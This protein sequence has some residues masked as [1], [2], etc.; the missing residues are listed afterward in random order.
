MI[1][2]ARLE[3]VAQL[4]R[5]EIADILRRDIHDPLIGFVTLTEVEVSPDLHHGKV[6]FSVLGTPEQVKDSIKGVLRA[7]KHINALLADRIDLRYIPKLR[8]V[9]DE[10]AAKAQHMAQLLRQEQEQLGPDLERHDAEERAQQASAE[11]S[12]A[13]ADLEDDEDFDDEFED[14]DLDEEDFGDDEDAKDESED[15]ADEGEGG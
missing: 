14:E 6:F 4:I 15:E 12:A 5:A 2:N 8:F 9:Y 13:A 7:R 11:A 10:T 3:R 1:M